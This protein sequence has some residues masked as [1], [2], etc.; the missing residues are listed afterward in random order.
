[1]TAKPIAPIQY[2]GELPDGW[3]WV[4]FQFVTR[5]G[6]VIDTRP[7]GW[8][9]IDEATKRAGEFMNLQGN[10]SLS[11]TSYEGDGGV[12]RV[13]ELEHIA[14][15]PMAKIEALYKKYEEEERAEGNE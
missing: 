14:V 11:L 8:P 12:V 7:E 10:S 15:F 3:M 2:D 13:S 4:C 1:M 6:A 9:S 5:G